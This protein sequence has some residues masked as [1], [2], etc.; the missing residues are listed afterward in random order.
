MRIFIE[1]VLPSSE[2]LF[3]SA[4]NPD[5]EVMVMGDEPNV[6]T[7]NAGAIPKTGA[8]LVGQPLIQNPTEMT[9]EDRIVVLEKM[10]LDLKT[11]LQFKTLGDNVMMARIREELD[12]ILNCKKED[13]I[14]LIIKNIKQ[15]CKG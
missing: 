10:L 7:T 12:M 6:K 15:Q 1:S 4:Y 2:L 13:R 14:V 9:L 5:H 3:G 11:Q 8:I